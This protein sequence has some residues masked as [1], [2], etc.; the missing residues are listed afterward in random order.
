MQPGIKYFHVLNIASDAVMA[1]KTRSALTALGIIFGVAAVIS[2]MAVG[3]GAKKEILDQMKLVGVNNIIITPKSDEAKKTESEG[4]QGKQLKKG[5]SAGISLQD[6]WAIR[7][8]IP[9]V[10]HISPEVTYETMGIYEGIGRNIRLS[11]VTPDFFHTFNLSLEKGSFFGEIE[12]ENSIPV[13]VIGSDIKSRM[14]PYKDPIGEFIKC[15]GI[16]FKVI[17][18]LQSR[19]VSGQASGNLGISNYNIH[20]YAPIQTVLNRV[21]DRSVVTSKLLSGGS[22][23]FGGGDFIIFSDGSSEGQ[24]AFNQL[25][26]IVVQVSESGQLSKTSEVIT[27]MLKRRHNNIEDFEVKIPELLLKQEQRTK[28]I[29]NI[30]LGAIASI[31]LLVGGIGIMNIMLAS[32]LE[33]I[34]EIGVRLAIGARRR[35]I[36]LQFLSEAVIIS[37][38]GGIAGIL[39]GLGLSKAITR[40]ADILTIISPWSILIS[41]GVSAAVGIAFGYMPARKAASQDPVTSLRYE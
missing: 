27:R 7:D 21:K 5:F 30:V 22:T 20:V 25:D 11:G 31:S 17:G 24:T 8:V 32:V 26:K 10:M 12:M 28:D 37:V 41:F 13:C 9:G 36:V 6:A 19:P 34:K 4:E 40:F 15:S 33:R 35:D 1:N 29:F 3:N 38:S 2:M 23:M 18:V 14:F 39:L 16:W